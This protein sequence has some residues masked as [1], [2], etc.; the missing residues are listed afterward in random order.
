M[1]LR[2]QTKLVDALKVD[3]KGRQSWHGKKI[4]T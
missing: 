4:W 3:G 1:Q 2:M